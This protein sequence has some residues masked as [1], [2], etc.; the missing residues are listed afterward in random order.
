MM[1]NLVWTRNA[2]TGCHKKHCFSL[3][4][5]RYIGNI[6]LAF[7]VEYRQPLTFFA[8][9]NTLKI[10]RLMA[11]KVHRGRLCIFEPSM[12]VFNKGNARVYAV[13]T[14][15]GYLCDVS[16]RKMYSHRLEYFPVNSH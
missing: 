2:F 4:P 11:T 6:V 3:A 10:T 7:N 13:C 1:L 12:S 14:L 9:G 5:G 8:S 16:T 15:A